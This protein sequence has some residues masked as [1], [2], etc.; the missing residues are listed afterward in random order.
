MHSQLQASGAKECKVRTC[1]EKLK[2][3]PSLV[4]LKHRKTKLE[5]QLSPGSVN[6]N[7]YSGKFS[8][9]QDKEINNLVL[10]S[11]FSNKC[12]LRMECLAFSVLHCN[13]GFMFSV[14]HSDISVPFVGTLAFSMTFYMT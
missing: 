13:I 14:S 6:L 5:F 12:L 2:L 9:K 10:S 11:L 3:M 8:S 7:H 1:L 4:S